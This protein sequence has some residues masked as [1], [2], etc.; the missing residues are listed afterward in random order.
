MKKILAIA[1][2]CLLLAACGKDTV[3]LRDI[4]ERD[5]NEIVATLY[6]AGI[7]ASKSADAKGKSFSVTVANDDFARGIAVLHAQGLPREARPSLSDVFKTGSFAPTAFEE[8]VRFIYG[9]SQELERTISYMEGALMVRVHVVIP[10]P[11]RRRDVTPIPSAS[12][13]VNYDDRV[14][15]DVQ[16]PRIRKMV[17]ESIE[18]LDETNVD[19]LAVPVK[20][21]LA[22][23]AAP[24][25]V[26]FL[27]FSVPPGAAPVLTA[28]VAAIVVCLGLLGFIF[29]AS[30]SSIFKQAR[31][32]L[33][34]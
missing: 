17:S 2:L 10:E 20:V 21:D 31:A 7:A 19:V 4:S 3:L 8:R 15:F 5:A 11:S 27:G 22:K 30:L 12:V 24:P 9:V 25:S 34:K 1:T 32:K 16:V 29:R 28:L 33:P 26:D 14:R 6:T 13:F 23:L 18:G